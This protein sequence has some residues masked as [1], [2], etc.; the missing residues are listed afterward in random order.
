MLLIPGAKNSS[1][2]RFKEW[3]RGDT[4]YKHV[5]QR[6]K[7]VLAKYPGSKVRGFLW[8][9]GESD[10]YWGRD[11]A[12]LLDRT[13]VQ[14]RRDIAGAAGDSIPFILGG[15]VTYWVDGYPA[16]KITDSVV[17][18]TPQRVGFTGYA[19]AR[20]PFVIRKP[21]NSINAIHFDAAG[22]RILGQRYFEAYQLLRR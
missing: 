11:Y 21:D 4:L 2:F 16:A 1:S 10:V 15:F 7:Y 5:V 6:V 9:Q 17:R 18:E 13:I 8:H 14:I 19:S 20:E 22:Q 12:Q 3:N